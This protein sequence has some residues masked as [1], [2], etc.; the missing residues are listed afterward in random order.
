[1]KKIKFVKLIW[2]RFIEKRKY[3]FPVACFKKLRDF[4]NIVNHL[5][6][7]QESIER[8]DSKVTALQNE[9]KQLQ[10]KEGCSI[11]RFIVEKMDVENFS[12]N[13]ESIEVEEVTGT[14]N[15]GI[16]HNSVVHKAGVTS[17]GDI[18][19]KNISNKEKKNSNSS[20][21]QNA[22]EYI[23]EKK[24]TLTFYPNMLNKEENR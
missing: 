16:V 19:R 7:L 5:L 13:L 24:Y 2:L 17:A 9:I 8:L 23:N 12:L 10:E 1:M 11:E 3:A 4:D 14:L 6:S 15:V 18:T 22:K 21:A 20:S